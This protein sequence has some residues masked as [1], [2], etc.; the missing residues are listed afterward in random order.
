M[1]TFQLPPQDDAGSALPWRMGDRHYAGWLLEHRRP[2]RSLFHA[3]V[4]VDHLSA[5]VLQFDT[6]QVHSTEAEA[7]FHFTRQLHGGVRTEY[8]FFSEVC[9]AMTG[10]GRML[11]VGSY[12]GLSELSHYIDEHRPVLALRIVG[13]ET[14]D[15]PTEG[16]LVAFARMYFA[17]HERMTAVPA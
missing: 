16:R 13:W 2:E 7:H 15:N 8:E 1:N 4:L 12:R 3:V 9:G 11:V 6:E 14:M 5:Q 17:R 10:I